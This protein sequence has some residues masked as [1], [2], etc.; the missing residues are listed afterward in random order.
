MS[1]HSKWANIKH[2]KSAQDAKRGKVFTKLTKEIMLAA[3]LGG[4]DDSCNPRLRTAIAKARESNVPKDNIDRAIKKGSGELE[5]VNYEEIVFEG[6][7]PGGMAVMIETMTDKRSRT[8]PEIKNLLNKNGGSMADAGAVSYLFE[9]KGIIVL[10]A[11]NAVEED[12]FSKAIESG[13]DDFESDEGI[14]IIKT[15]REKFHEVFSNLEPYLLEKK[16]AVI[17]SG[18][19]YVPLN[20]LDLSPD[21]E[22]AV[23]RFMDAI[24]SH[25]DVQNVYTNLND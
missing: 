17:E 1:G 15:E 3:K 7:G 9:H 11:A 13:A 16:I 18:L 4:G 24:E 19:Q 10:D 12:L 23:E 25:D 20:P 14:F 5:G 21:K 6:Y 8:I 22:S 2:K